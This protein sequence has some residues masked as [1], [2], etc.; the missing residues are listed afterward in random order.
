MY[1]NKDRDILE[2]LSK[3]KL[4]S[5]HQI[6]HNV[7]NKSLWACSKRLL[8]LLK[9][10]DLKR[11]KA[12][13]GRYE[14]LY[15]LTSIG[16]KRYQDTSRGISNSAI[17]NDVNLRKIEHDHLISKIY[18]QLS[19]FEFI[20]EI[21]SEFELLTLG[22]LKA[23]QKWPDLTFKLFDGKQW[24]TFALEVE[25]SAKTKSQYKDILLNYYLDR[26]FDF[27]LYLVRSPAL[28]KTLLQNDEP[29]FPEKQRKLGV[30]FISDF[31]KDPIDTSFSNSKGKSFSLSKFQRVGING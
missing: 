7:V 13:Y 22:E 23:G 11:I 19:K 6:N 2:F 25:I 24:F 30:G 27:V 18:S 20:Q 29:L 5:A 31:L 15:Y 28:V 3:V 8:R 1:P 14:F 10:G 16:L 12:S 4:A 21:K 17:F 9:Q 26:R